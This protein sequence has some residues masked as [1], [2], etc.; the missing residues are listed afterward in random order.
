L[1][2]AIWPPGGFT[3]HLQLFKSST[4]FSSLQAASKQLIP[5]DLQLVASATFQE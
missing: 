5:T 3:A 1:G 4:G 2:Q